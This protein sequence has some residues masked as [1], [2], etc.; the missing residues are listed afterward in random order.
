MKQKSLQQFAGGSQVA[1]T[2]IITDREF[3]LIPAK[4]LSASI[5]ENLK[6]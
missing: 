4:L 6:E 2:G 3:E 5:L 1:G